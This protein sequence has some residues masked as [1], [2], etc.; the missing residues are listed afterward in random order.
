MELITEPWPLG[1]KDGGPWD[2]DTAIT[3]KHNVMHICTRS[4]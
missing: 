4:N 1:L 3:V 2:G